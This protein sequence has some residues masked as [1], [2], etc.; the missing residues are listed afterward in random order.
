V[1]KAKGLQRCEPRGS[2]RVKA[3]RRS[4]GVTSKTP[5]NVRK[6][7]GV[8]GNE[9][10]HSQGNSHFGRCSPGGLLKLQRAIARVKTQWLVTFFISLESSWNLDVLNELALLIWTSEIQVMAK[11]RAKSQT[12]SLTP[13]HKKLGIDPIYLA[14][15]GRVTYHWKAFDESYNFA[16]NCIAIWGL[17]AKLWGSKVAGVPFGAISGLPLGSPQ[18][19]KPFGCSLHGQP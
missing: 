14:A 12:A 1:T 5:E 9:P 18:R 17:L 13:D 2:S 7:E 8:W 3:R 4:S 15:G 10:S 19:E 11:R 16:S 6:C